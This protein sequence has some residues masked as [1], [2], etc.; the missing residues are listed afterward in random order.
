MS[1]QEETTQPFDKSQLRFGVFLPP[2]HNLAENPTLAIQRDF[3]LMEH[4]DRLGYD[5]A[6]I[7]EHHSGGLEF[8]SSPEI[9]IAEA[10]AR[11]R[12]I[13]FGTG[14]VSLPFHNPFMVAQRITQ[15]DHQLR[16]RLMFGVGAG[17]LATDVYTL[18]LEGTQI[19]QRTNDNLDV[20][21]RLLSGEVVSH[22]TDEYTLRDAR[23]HLP[24]F[25]L[26]H[27]ELAVAS[28]GT[29]SGPRLAGKYGGGLLSLGLGA[30]GESDFLVDT[31]RHW[32]EAT[33][34]AGTVPNRASWRIAGPIHIAE[35]RDQAREDVRY[36]IREW[37]LYLRHSPAF[38]GF[39]VDIMDRP[40]DEMVDAFL[41]T[42]SAVVGTPDD[43]IEH[44]ENWWDRSGG[45]GCWLDLANNWAQFAQKKRSYELIADCVVPHFRGSNKGRKSS[46]DWS[47]E[48]REELK[49]D[50]KKGIDQEIRKWS[51][52]EKSV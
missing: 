34:E 43:L 4:L 40:P 5:E 31:L 50:R 32:T 15:L 42:G 51:G 21:M 24:P 37:M 8:V 27:P 39:A 3:E 10:A 25:T 35:S 9:F 23:C 26:P 17:S 52:N 19:R 44:I 29:P 48:R 20:I 38:Q 18:G 22:S 46:F 47:E 28:T 33:A 11:T 12:R 41:E 16:G 7:G 30:S 6:W 13:R 2:F 49:V 1:A 36:G 14:V 45:F